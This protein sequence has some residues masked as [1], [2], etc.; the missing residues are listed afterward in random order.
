MDK[1]ELKAGINFSPEKLMDIIHTLL[2]EENV[3][4]VGEAAE[5]TI[6][7]A[8]EYFCG[9]VQEE[10]DQFEMNSYLYSIASAA[11]SFA[12]QEGFKEGIRLC[13]TLQVL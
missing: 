6:A 9:R 8:D 10:S 7:E 4:F 2:C 11:G 13:R 1:M 12:Y 3:D 5:N